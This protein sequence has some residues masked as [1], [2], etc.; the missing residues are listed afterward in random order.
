M[1]PAIVNSL[2]RPR[3]HIRTER[4]ILRLP[5]LSDVP[6]IVRF[7]RVNRDFH[8][9]WEPSRSADYYSP[10]Y[11]TDQVERSASNFADDRALNLFLFASQGDPD[12]IG[13]LNFSN[14]V[15]GAAHFCHCGY[16]LAESAQG[17]GLMEEALGTAIRYLFDDVGMHRIMANYLPRNVRSASLLARLGFQVEG[18]AKQYL[19]INGRWEDHVLTSLVNRDWT[20]ACGETR[21]A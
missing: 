7:V 5:E 10:E 8:A 15:R 16:A 13:R 2:C 20:Q 4:L 6:E 11:W 1:G 21:N 9:P 14:F 12:I 17:K 19:L 18:V 3:P